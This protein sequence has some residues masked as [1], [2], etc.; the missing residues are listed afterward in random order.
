MDNTELYRSLREILGARGVRDGAALAGQDP[1]Y[2]LQNLA[3]SFLVLPE[4]TAQV[5]AVVRLC[6]QAGM[7]RAMIA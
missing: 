5:A 6:R 7:S 3:G 2:H 1:G 4:S